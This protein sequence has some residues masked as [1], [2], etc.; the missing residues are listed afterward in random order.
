M[1]NP[2]INT[3]GDLPT[4]NIDT[5][6]S[7]SF[8]DTQ[9]PGDAVTNT[10]RMST[11]GAW[12]FGYDGF[13]WNRLR[14]GL[15]GSTSS[16]LGMI[17]SAISMATGSLSTLPIGKFNG[18]KP[19]LLDTQFAEAQ[20][21]SRGAILFANDEPPQA[22]DDTNRVLWTAERPLP[23]LTAG[24]ILTTGAGNLLYS[25][26]ATV[27][28]NSN[29]AKVTPGRLYEVFGF[30]QTGKFIQL[31]NTTTMPAD[32]A[33]PL[34]S[35]WVPAMSNFSFSWPMGYPCSVGIAL[36]TSTTNATKTIS[37]LGDTNLFA[38]VA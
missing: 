15:T 27:V 19:S 21:T 35:L 4:M 29:L 6:G 7:S 12:N 38:L 28:G 26:L 25:A 1:A 8:P 22:Q 3:R 17:N 5:V 36:S 18:T 13:T 14:V 37:V 9:I 20:V 32:T 33:V 24:N 34:W 16:S 31:H 23:D 10:T 30:T 11:L 2:N